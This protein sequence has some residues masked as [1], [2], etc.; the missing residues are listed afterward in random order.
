VILLDTCVV[1][2]VLR[3]EPSES[4][5]VWLESLQEDRVFLPSL[6]LGELQKG[7]VLPLVDSLLAATALQHQAILA[8]RNTKDYEDSGAVVV[9]LWE[10]RA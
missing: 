9:N 1:S 7:R 10:F 4:V 2:E 5:L 3:P 6:V 8:T